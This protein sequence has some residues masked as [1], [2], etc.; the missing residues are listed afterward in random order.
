MSI[1]ETVWKFLRW[2]SLPEAS[3]AAIMGNIYQESSFDQ[4]EIEVGSGAGFGLFQWSFERRTELEAYGTDLTHQLNFF[5]VELTGKTPGA[6][7][8]S[9]QWVDKSG[10][11]SHTDFMAGNGS[12]ADLTA[13]FCVC[14]E[15]AGTPMMQNRIN[16]ANGYYSQF[17]GTV[18]ESANSNSD[19]LAIEATN[20]QVVANSTEYGDVLFGRRYRITVSDDSGNALDV[21]QLRCTFNT[22]KT[23]Q[24]EPNSSEITIYNLN[25]KTENAIIMTGKRVTVEAGYEGSQFGLIFDGDILQT[26]R[27]RENG[28]TFKLTIIALD[29]DRTINFEIAN[30]SIVKGQT[31][32]SVVDHI[33]AKHSINIGSISDKLKGQTLTRGKV[34]FGKAS[35]YLRQIAKSKDLHFYMDDGKLNLISMDDLPEGEIFDI[36]PSSGL[37]GTPEQNDYGISGQCLINPQ[38]K[39]NSLIHIDNSLVRAKQIDINGSNASPAGGL[40]AGDSTSSTVRNKIIAE[41][42]RL[43]DDPNVQ[44]SEDL[45]LRGQTVNG[46]TYYDCSLFVKHC[47]ETA[48]L[49]LLDIT[50][51]QWAQTKAKGVITTDISSALAG[52]IVFWFDSNGVCGHVAIYGGNNDIYAARSVNKAA[53]DQVSY[54]PIYGDYK[55]GTPESLKNADGGAF[56]SAN[57]DT[58]STSDTSQGLF[59]SLDKDGIYRVIRLETSADTRGNDYYMNFT[60]IDQLGGTI[61]AVSN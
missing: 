4:T 48:G 58:S 38:I 21:S 35:D 56:P 8:A 34:L 55:I 19:A 10:Y 61:A 1:E 39:L 2:Y 29:S 31:M 9:Y 41:A 37:I 45:N 57:N 28:T 54:G 20:Y 49:D 30:Y 11:L 52:D 32:R 7:G 51:N 53:A 36:S 25:V 6:T 12:V 26:I 60:C 16:A 17:T 59:R 33:V 3:A 15:R 44:Y 42:K 43:C 23:I 14:W 50:T 5:W 18:A 24:M 27:E 47:Y 22:I 46:I 40:T 13:A